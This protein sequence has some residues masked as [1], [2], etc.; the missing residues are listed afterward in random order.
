MRELYPAVLVL[1]AVAV[2]DA[3]P[4]G[5]AT[6]E[7]MREANAM[8]QAA[9]GAE[10][11]ARA[12]DLFHERLTVGCGNARLLE[13]VDAHQLVAQPIARFWPAEAGDAALVR[14]TG[15]PAA[16]NTSPAPARTARPC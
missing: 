16:A 8:L 4:Y 5:A 14:P 6:L 10:A 3:P 9:T 12:D 13:V 2:R 15:D 11:A 7:G 1:E